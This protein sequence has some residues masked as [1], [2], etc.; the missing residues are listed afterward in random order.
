MEVA[1]EPA[2]DIADESSTAA[3]QQAESQEAVLNVDALDEAIDK[4]DQDDKPN[5]AAAVDNEKKV[6][7]RPNTH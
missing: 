2:D 3:D 4:S 5:V 6:G 1:T 7:S